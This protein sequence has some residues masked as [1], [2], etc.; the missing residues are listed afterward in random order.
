MRTR[1]LSWTVVLILAT[2]P[3]TN[4]AVSQESAPAPKPEAQTTSAEHKT[5]PSWDAPMEQ[6]R[7]DFS[8]NEMEDGKKVNTR[9]YSMNLTTNEGNEI[10]I[11]T[12]VPIESKN[13]ANGNE[14]Q[15][16]DVGTNIF[17][18]IGETRGQSDLTVRADLSNFAVPGPSSEKPEILP[19]VR[20]IKLG[21]TVMLP[22][23]SKTFV[24]VS[25]DDPNSKRQFQM[26]VTVTKVK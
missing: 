23:A 13:S 5:K 12:R 18:R 10:K 7:L 1:T 16:L 25:A 9:Q 2:L 24:M 20:Q 22:P 4:R 17:A 26:E 11:G 8:I 3:F 6:Y 14:F 15:Y 19:I 21:G